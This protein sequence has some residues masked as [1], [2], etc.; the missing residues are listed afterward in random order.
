VL[1]LLFRLE[2]EAA[3]GLTAEVSLGRTIVLEVEA[4]L[5]LPELWSAL[6]RN[7]L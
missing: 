2:E 6:Y 4:E 1:L 5:I 3:Q 7:G